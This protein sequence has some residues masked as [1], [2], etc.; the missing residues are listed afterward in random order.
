MPT[1]IPIRVLSV[2]TAENTQPLT[3]DGAR[4]LFEAG[5][6]RELVGAAPCASQAELKAACKKAYLR[7]HP[8]RGGD[9]EVFKWVYAASE[10]LRCDDHFLVF[11][12]KPPSWAA[13]RLDRL[14]EY[15]E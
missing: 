9:A 5:R 6:L 2:P 4:V 14:Q 12:G 10:V 3:S 8:D 11:E 1:L 15:A 13:W 7:H